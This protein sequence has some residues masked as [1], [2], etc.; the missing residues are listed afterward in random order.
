MTSHRAR[1]ALVAAVLVLGA[2]NTPSAGS[3]QPPVTSTVAATTVP[4][5]SPATTASAAPLPSPTEIAGGASANP[6]ALDPCTLMTSA[7][8]STMI[9]IKLGAGKDVLVDQ[10]RECVFENGATRV[11]LIL[12]PPA[13]DAT[14]AQSYYDSERGQVPA[15]I[16]VDDVSG[17][18]DR[19]SYGM[20]AAAGTSIS[21]LFVLKGI[22]AFDLY[23]QF[24]GCSEVASLT[25]AQTIV[26]RLP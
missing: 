8:A 22:Q 20:G 18:G 16:T 24:P 25:Q 17:V 6:T 3:S 14:T 4:A 13:P 9:G 12:A 15:D 2:C 1:L 26:G 5:A 23:C 19:A 21:A 11:S 10:D 7:E